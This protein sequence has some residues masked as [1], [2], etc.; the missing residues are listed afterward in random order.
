MARAQ[1]E[2]IYWRVVPM[3]IAAMMAS[4][5]LLGLGLAVLGGPGRLSQAFALSSLLAVMAAV[6]A[7]VLWL[8]LMLVWNLLV[9]RLRRRMGVLRAAV[10][11]SAGLALLLSLAPMWFWSRPQADGRFAVM[12]ILWGVAAAAISAGLAHVSFR[13]AMDIWAEPAGAG[14][15]GTEA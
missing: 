15:E 8:P 13:G 4:G 6:A 12:M 1:R 14:Q 2:P 5:A 9:W 11:V 7:A 3:G 10:A